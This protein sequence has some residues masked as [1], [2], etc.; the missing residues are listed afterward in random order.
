MDIILNIEYIGIVQVVFIR[1]LLMM[2]KITVI[3][4]KYI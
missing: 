2:E 3:E 4:E 1:D